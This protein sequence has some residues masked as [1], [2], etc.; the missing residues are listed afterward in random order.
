M[1]VNRVPKGRGTIATQIA[2]SGWFNHLTLSVI[3][4]NVVWIGYDA[5]QNG[6]DEL[7]NAKT[8]FIVMESAAAL[9]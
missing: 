1:Y 8:Q 7:F 2:T 6:E 9:N 5:D 3:L 4:F